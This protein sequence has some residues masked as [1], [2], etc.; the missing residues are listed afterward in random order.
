M[1]PTD[2]GRRG[3]GKASK[4]GEVTEN[5]R[6]AAAP[7]AVPH[8][9]EVVGGH[10]ER[11]PPLRGLSRRGRTPHPALG[12]AACGALLPTAPNTKVEERSQFNR[13]DIYNC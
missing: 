8:T 6:R 7:P 13:A 5:G 3:E 11:S 12:A 1:A 9:L 2:S 4:G 10:E